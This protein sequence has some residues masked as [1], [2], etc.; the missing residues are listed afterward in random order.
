V[1]NLD[2]DAT[3]WRWIAGFHAALYRA[4]LRFRDTSRPDQ[5]FFRSLVLPFPKARQ[6]IGTPEP[7][8]VQHLHFIETIKVNRFKSNT[9]YISCNNKQLNYECVWAP[10]DNTDLWLCIFALNVCDWKDLGATKMQPARGCA[11]CYVLPSF[12]PP[13]GA[14]FAVRS[15]IILPN[16]DRLDPFAR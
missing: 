9:D 10:F 16:H 2:V 7:L 11:G 5:P 8:L 1:V 14:A 12:T 15:P 4:P 6:D 3:V 13:A